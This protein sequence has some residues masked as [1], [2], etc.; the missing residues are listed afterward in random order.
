MSKMAIPT[1]HALIVAGPGRLEHHADVPRPSAGANEVLIRVSAVA[2]NPVDNKAA[3]LSP[4]TGAI[5]GCDFSGTVHQA[6]NNDNK[7]APGQRVC[8]LVFQDPAEH[9]HNGAFAEWVVADPDFLLRVPPAMSTEEAASLGIGLATCGL[10][11]YH[12]LALPRPSAPS[13]VSSPVLV[14][15]ASTATGTL[16]L[17]LLRL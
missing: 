3:E 15:G 2:L 14:Y 7:L 4:A 12:E 10:A 11:L 13:S 5:A 8:G 6:S 16:A 9:L 1:Q 17:Q